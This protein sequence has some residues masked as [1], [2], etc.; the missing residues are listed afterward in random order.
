M[1]IKVQK[2]T[3]LINIVLI[4]E[5]MESIWSPYTKGENAHR[6]R[7]ILTNFGHFDAGLGDTPIAILGGVTN[8]QIRIHSQ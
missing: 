3:I 6:N 5:S 4:A 2:R 1:V 7:R 8:L